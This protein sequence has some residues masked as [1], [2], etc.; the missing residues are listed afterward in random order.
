MRRPAVLSVISV[1]PKR[2]GGA[3][4]YA[5][6]LSLQL[7]QRGFDSVLCFERLPAG[8]VLEYLTLPNVR[9]DVLDDRSSMHWRGSIP[10]ARLLLRYRPRIVH[11]S[12]THALSIY[13]WIAKA[14][15]GSRVFF[16]DQGSRSTGYVIRRAPL[17]KRLIAR[18]INLPVSRTIAIS[19]YTYQCISEL[20][21]VP[22]TR[23]RRIY[24]ALDLDRA[25]RGAGLGAAFRKEHG[26]PLDR[27]LALQVSALIPEKGIEDLLAAAKLV[28]IADPSIH[29][30]ILGE[31][32]QGSELKRLARKLG[33]AE[34]VTWTGLIHDPLGSGAFDAADIV[35]QMSRW[36][37][38]FGWVI[39][40]AMAAEK[41]VVGTRVGAIPELI[42]HGCTGYVVPRGDTVEMARHILELAGNLELRR[43]FGRMATKVAQEKFDVHMT[44]SE[45]LDLYLAN[46]A[47]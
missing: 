44:V 3:E 35:C 37:E 17:A 43:S 6:E 15:C 2:I 27:T 19:N 24:N 31:G 32:S 18:A 30:A 5:R 28:V 4:A 20:G 25:A 39:A 40:E 45:L 21:F 36:E 7:D 29:F 38:A 1:S 16:T 12:F 34:H 10:F 47:Y 46:G 13:P 9:F 8:R 14:L 33:I 22:A 42:D 11:L 26:I 23:I 41:P